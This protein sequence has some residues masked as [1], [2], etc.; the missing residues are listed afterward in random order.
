MT[1]IWFDKL[2]QHPYVQELLALESK[3]TDRREFHANVKELLL[4]MGAD[5]EFLSLVLKRNLEDT[6]WLN[7]AWSLYN[8]PYLH[9]YETDDFILKIHLFPPSKNWTPGVAA[10]AIH[11]HNNYILTTNAFFGSGYESL[12]FDKAVKVD[13]KTLRSGMRIRKHFHQ[14]DWNPSMVDSWEPHIV[15]VPEALSAT[16][17]IWTPDKKRATDSLRNVGILKAIKGPLRKIIQALG[18]ADKFGISRSHTYQWY[19]AADG[20]G[21]MAVEEEEYFA[22][23][24]AAVGPAIDDY[25]IQM[26]FAF[27]QRMGIADTDWIRQQYESK[28]FPSYFDKWVEKLLRGEAIEDVYHR[29]EI[30]IPQKRYTI[31]DIYKSAGQV[32]PSNS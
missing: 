13:P 31:A 22:P 29:E 27:V 24:K 16:M 26:V 28:Q 9:V 8:I 10:H 17:L 15:F 12:L 2:Q 25:S 21:F 32:V 1:Q 4:K 19:A 11:H 18:M 20:K 14:Q 23:T 5:K 6:G 3:Y 30:N 7:Q